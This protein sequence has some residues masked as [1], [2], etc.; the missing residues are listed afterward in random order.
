MPNSNRK[1][2]EREI[3]NMKKLIL[4]KLSDHRLFKAEMVMIMASVPVLIIMG[5]AEKSLLFSFTKGIGVFS[6]IMLM[7]SLFCDFLVHGE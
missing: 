4:Y 2:E 3:C 6:A 1:Q 5:F 7:V